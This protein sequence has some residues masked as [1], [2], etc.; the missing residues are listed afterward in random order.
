M[1]RESR[2]DLSTVMGHIILVNRI[3][4]TDGRTHLD[5][6]W[7][8][9]TNLSRELLLSMTDSMWEVVFWSLWVDP[10]GSFPSQAHPAKDQP[11]G[12]TDAVRY[13]QFFLW[14]LLGLFSWLI[15]MGWEQAD[16]QAEALGCSLR[17][18]ESRGKESEPKVI[19]RPAEV[20]YLFIHWPADVKQTQV[21]ES[22]RDNLLAW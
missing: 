10:R 15:H 3:P 12:Q 16:Q 18:E 20:L 14:D 6:N 17:L 5:C 11:L 2:V 21:A 8:H 9:Q 4:W 19:F 13:L 1:S 7:Q 22:F